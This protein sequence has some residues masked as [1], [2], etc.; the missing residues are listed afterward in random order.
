MS[1]KDP[2][3]PKM[4]PRGRP[5]A[6]GNDANRNA[7]GR[8]FVKI[9]QKLSKI[10]ADLLCEEAD[11]EIAEMV[12]LKPGSTWGQAVAK[13]MIIQAV[14][15]GDVGAAHFLNTCTNAGRVLEVN[16]NTPLDL[17]LYDRAQARMRQIIDTLPALPAPRE[18]PQ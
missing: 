13:A 3:K 10:T 18:E 8:P 14:V 15:N 16:V 11:A 1:K 5:F 4:K 17:S 6:K 7:S 12:G 2:F 9:H